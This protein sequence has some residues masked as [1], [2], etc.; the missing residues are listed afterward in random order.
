MK[1]IIVLAFCLFLT[2]RLSAQ[3]FSLSTNLL[4]WANLGTLNLQAGLSFSR[5]LT[6]HAG[7]RYN[8][9]DFGS[10][11]KGTDFRNK[12]RTASIG[13][14]YW[15]W[16]VYSSWW[17]GTR[18]QAEE[19]SRGGLLARP[20]TEEGLAAGVGLAFG[21]SRMLT[22]RW[23]LDFGLGFWGGWKRY[24]RYACPHCGRVLSDADGTPLLDRNKGFLL[25]SEDVQ[26][27]LTYI[28]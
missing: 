17:I 7:A 6:L 26:I 9:W 2:A 1:K 3:T 14:R 25:P 28:F 27:S 15:P 21:Y 4:D 22:G 24:S 13:L 19:Y 23:N 16:N 11:E 10:A 8:N 20:E 5:H 18:L 12:A